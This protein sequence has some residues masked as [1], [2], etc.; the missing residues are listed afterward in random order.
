MSAFG[1]HR[2]TV[3]AVLGGL[4]LASTWSSGA[5]MPQFGSSVQFD[6]SGP[7]IS[8][9]RLKGKAVLVIFFQSWCGICNGW[10]P[11]M[12]KELE[13]AHGNDRTLVMIAIKTDGGGV[14]GARDYLKSKGADLNKWCIGSDEGATFYQQ[15][16]GGNEL[17]GYV[18]VGASGDIVEQGRAGSFWTSGPDKGKYVLSSADLLKKCGKLE[19][20][21]PPD[22]EY[23]PELSKIVR[24]A[25][26]G[27]L[28]KALSLCGSTTQ[29]PKDAAAREGLKQDILAILDARLRIRMDILKDAGTAAGRRYEA[30]K[31]LTELAKESGAVPAA[32][33]ATALLGKTGAD[34]V[35]QRERSAE[36]AYLLA[37]QH[38]RKA[39]ARDRPRILRELAMVARTYEG[40]KYGQLAAE[41]SRPDHH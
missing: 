34:P 22:R 18:L 19:T 31:E 2:V 10:A 33:E 32:R 11:Q 23:P 1:K 21:L 12:I 16:S 14:S 38:L 25:E 24:L 7:A 35:I 6:K 30:Y 36:A 3:A 27:C 40:T 29:R 37:I 20:V 15:V 8:M 39:G 17:W 41:E 28:G 13:D 5:P 4:L 26:L 9:S